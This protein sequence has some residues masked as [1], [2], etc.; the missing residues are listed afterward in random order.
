MGDSREGVTWG[1]STA[2]IRRAAPWLY[3]WAT[4]VAC[5]EDA[6]PAGPDHTRVFEVKQHALRRSDVAFTYEVPTLFRTPDVLPALD[7]RALAFA[8]GRLYAGTSTAVLV[9][10]R[11]RFVVHTPGL[12]VLDLASRG[13][14]VVAASARE[15]RVLGA[16]GATWT[17]STADV[18]AVALGEDDVV[19][20]ATAR[21][22]WRWAPPASPELRA[23]LSAPRDLVVAGGR[24]YV[25]TSTGVARVVLDTGVVEAS[26]RAPSALADD[27]VRA[28][29]LSGDGGVL[30]VA[31]ARGYSTIRLA[32]GMSTVV[33]PQRGGLP[34]DRLTAITERDGVV[35]VG[36]EVGATALGVVGPHRSS[37][38]HY[39]TKRWIPD[40]R[41]TAVALGEGGTR[42]IATAA[43][44]TRIGFATT[45]LAERAARFEALLGAKHW[46]MDGFVDDDVNLLDEWQ[47]DQG[48]S[49]D[50]KDNDGLWTQMQVGPWC[51]AYAMTGD[52]AYYQRARKAMDVMFMLVDVPA[53]TFE[54]AGKSR[55]F[56]AR[57]LV[58]DDEGD[59]YTSKL[60]SDRWVK[61]AYRGRDYVWK[62]DTSS[63]EYAGH[64]FGFPLFHDLCA[65]TAEEKAEVATR[66]RQIADYL[67][68]G[69]FLLYDLDG[70]PTTFGRW[71]DLAASIV[72]P[73][74]CA[75]RFPLELC[76][77]SL[78]G[79]GWL[80]AMEILGHLLA[81]WHV[82]G[83]QKYYDAYEA[84]YVD[85]RYGELIPLRETTVTV[86]EPAIANHS[87]HELALLAYFT[88]LRYEPDEGRRAR[89]T[90]SILDFQ[91]YERRERNP[92]SVSVVASGVPLSEAQDPGLDDALETLRVW[93]EDWRTWRTDNSHRLDA[94]RWPDDRHRRPQFDAVFPYDEL[95]TMKW[96]TSPYAVEGGGSGRSVLAPTPWLIAY[97]KLR[98]YGVL[99]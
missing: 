87:D 35:L 68:A 79:G 77:S 90:K 30:W 41:V 1:N 69:Q 49:H 48:L 8:G 38:D 58:R 94:G 19:W 98:Y 96:N 15:V 70:E 25:A 67:I 7:V 43:G 85:Q 51:M 95:K 89:L 4:L 52:E 36:H 29:A 6:V 16:G 91:A 14:R 22:L 63:D 2:M 92:W 37:L 42:W 57:S 53:L 88:L 82:T 28:L 76:F 44:I 13:E 75:S 73:N 45:T 56:V 21:G 34:T 18:R 5:G 62:N 10:E 83:D 97:W 99:E 39:H 31:S 54:A 84:L 23:A 27:D 81:T 33:M 32:D 59:V 74:D 66:M 50:D 47:P 12:A 11:E 86:T 65:K 93:P 64:F 78:G 3:A 71:K 80:N 46:R 9:F 55:G 24:A 40:E 60:T 61:Q 17:S 72:A 26:W 20:L